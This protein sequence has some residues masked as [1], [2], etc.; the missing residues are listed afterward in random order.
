MRRGYW[1]GSV[2]GIKYGYGIIKAFGIFIEK[3]MGNDYCL[4]CV[5]GIVHLFGI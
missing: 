4:L 2:H 3:R 5:F 1:I